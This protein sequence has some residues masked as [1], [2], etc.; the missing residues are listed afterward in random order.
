M[1]KHEQKAMK[2]LIAEDDPDVAT[3]ITFGVR[4][5]WPDCQISVAPDGKTALERFDWRRYSGVAAAW[6]TRIVNRKD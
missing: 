2:L 1:K 3:A 5:N 6:L 4:M